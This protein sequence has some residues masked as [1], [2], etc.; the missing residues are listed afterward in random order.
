MLCV[1]LGVTN[2]HAFSE[3]LESKETSRRP[4]RGIVMVVRVTHGNASLKQHEHGFIWHVVVFVFIFLLRF[5]PQSDI[6]FFLLFSRLFT[7]ISD[8][9]GRLF[10]QFFVL[11]LLAAPRT[12]NA[13]T[14]VL[15]ICFISFVFLLQ[16]N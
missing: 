10:F 3:M 11:F 7:F 16:G 5:L 9:F 1:M 13:D 14:D 6:G 15:Q 2:Q 4:T 8:F 12:G